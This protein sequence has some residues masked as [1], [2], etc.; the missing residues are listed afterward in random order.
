MIRPFRLA[1]AAVLLAAPAVAQEAAPGAPP[2][3][4]VAGEGTI[5]AAPNVAI[6]QLGVVTQA[7]DAKAA[8]AENSQAMTHI[9]DALKASGIASRDL[10][11]SGFGV[12]PRVSEPPRDQDP[13]AP[14]TPKIVGYAVRNTVTLRVRDL[15]QVGAILDQVV[16][17]GANTVSG[18]DFTL[19]DPDKA[20]DEAR[21]AAV[22]DARSKAE[23]YAAAADV[24]LGR[25]IRL[26]DGGSARP[27][28]AAMAMKSAD[29]AGGPAPI[30]GGEI[31]VQ[32]QV[33][34]TW[35]LQ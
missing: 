2:S 15:P 35:E 19:A 24:R 11:T 25:V 33:T 21:Q 23:L 3:L 7:P 14:W 27:M 17:L 6:I 30:E 29:S 20:E 4:T 8:L 22:R 12:E 34:V 16:T 32:A 5:H 13:D 26:Q 31:T 28:M 9:L 1:F 10:Q 18:P